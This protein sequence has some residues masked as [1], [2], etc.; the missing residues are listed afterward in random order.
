MIMIGYRLYNNTEVR[1][2]RPPVTPRNRRWRIEGMYKGTGCSGLS[3]LRLSSLIILMQVA[4]S[5]TLTVTRDSVQCTVYSVRCS[6][7]RRR[8][9]S[10]E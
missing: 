7:T 2:E 8:R 9:K 3:V 6:R 4:C 10:T 5:V 1:L